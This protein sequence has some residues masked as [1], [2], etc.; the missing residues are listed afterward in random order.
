M[1]EQTR[2]ISNLS[3]CPVHDLLLA[4]HT[5][6][7]HFP[8]IITDICTSTTTFLQTPTADHEFLTRLGHTQA[9]F[10]KPATDADLTQPRETAPEHV[11]PVVYRGAQATQDLIA[12]PTHPE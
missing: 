6:A 11:P 2:E 9:H 7:N 12:S 1:T 3:F 5:L 4:R 10:T 8:T